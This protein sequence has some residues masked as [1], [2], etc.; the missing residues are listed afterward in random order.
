MKELELTRALKANQDACIEA[1]GR[2]DMTAY[3]A[4]TRE[5]ARLMDQLRAIWRLRSEGGTP[6]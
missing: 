1:L 6:A 4:L 5:E 2:N 3:E